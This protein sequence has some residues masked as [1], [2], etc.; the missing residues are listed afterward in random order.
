MATEDQLL[1]IMPFS[2]KRIPLFAKPLNDAMAEFDINTA[3]RQSAFIA[4]IAHESGE[5]RYVRELASGEAYDTAAKAIALGNT[6]EADGDGQRYKG[7]GLIQITGRKN[8]KL[9]GAA[10][11]LDLLGHPELLEEPVNACRSAA[12]F[13]KSNGLNQLADGGDFR[14]ITRLINGG[15]NGMAE[16]QKYYGRALAIIT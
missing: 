7:R 10:L 5:L 13:W 8:Y 12:W 14:R 1:K 4:Q 15:Y 3:K 9:C 2:A 6:P 16:R 11:G